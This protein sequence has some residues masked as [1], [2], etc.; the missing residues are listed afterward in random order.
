MSTVAVANSQSARFQLD[1]SPP[2]S[3]TPPS[4]PPRDF[5]LVLCNEVES[6]FFSAFFF[7]FGQLGEGGHLRGECGITHKHT[8]TQTLLIVAFVEQLQI[9]VCVFL[10]LLLLPLLL[11]KKN[12]CQLL[13]RP[14]P[15]LCHAPF[16]PVTTL[17]NYVSAIANKSDAARQQLVAF[18][19]AA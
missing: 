18:S 5:F 15:L 3:P 2:P 14:L 7:F 13:S 6:S 16:P 8:H 4:P 12:V 10:L 1:G 11:A 9:C 17:R 19:S